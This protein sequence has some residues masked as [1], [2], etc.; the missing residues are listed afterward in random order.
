MAE[1]RQRDVGAFSIIAGDYAKL[2]LG[3]VLD[4]SLVCRRAVLSRSRPS[5]SNLSAYRK[6]WDPIERNETSHPPI[7]RASSVATPR[8]LLAA[9]ILPSVGAERPR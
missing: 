3:L 8:R 5:P 6:S 2:F 1:T 7:A 4:L 9:E